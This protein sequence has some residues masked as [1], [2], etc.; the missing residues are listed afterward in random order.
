MVDSV[1]RIQIFLNCRRGRFWE[2]V[3]EIEASLADRDR[4]LDRSSLIFLFSVDF[5]L[6]WPEIVQDVIR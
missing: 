5:A 3:E 6:S 4:R 1:Q 2:L